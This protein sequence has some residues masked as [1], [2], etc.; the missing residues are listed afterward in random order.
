MTLAVVFMINDAAIAASA[1]ASTLWRLWSRRHLL[2]WT[3]AAHTAAR[4]ETVHP[5]RAAWRHMWVSPAFSLAVAFGLLFANPVALVAAL[6]LLL[7]WF[8]AP[9]IAVWISGPRRPPVERISQ[10][11]RKFLRRV[12]RRTWLYFETFVGP[13]DNWLPPDNYQEEPYPEIAYR[14]SPTNIGMMFLSSL[15]AWKL[16]YIGLNDLAVRLRSALDSLD[17]LELVRHAVVEASGAPLR[18]HG[19]QWQPRC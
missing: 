12:A 14:T 8:L 11:D 3:S 2:E 9:E 6:P 4:F 18:V 15:T 17:R 1:I 10:D 5:R 7:V 19:R 16:G 13:E